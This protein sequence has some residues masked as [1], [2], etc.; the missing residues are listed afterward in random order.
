MSR[1]R[2]AASPWQSFPAVP[3]NAPI[4][5]E[6]F[7]AAYAGNDITIVTDDDTFDTFATAFGQVVSAS[8]DEQLVYDIVSAYL[9]GE[10]RFINGS[11]RGP[12]LALS[13]GD[14]DGSTQGICGAVQIKMHPGAVRAFEDAGHTVADCAKP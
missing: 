2:F 3:L 13:F 14:I 10:D 6:E 12:F 1:F 5:V 4:P 9:A 8:M 11:P 7:R